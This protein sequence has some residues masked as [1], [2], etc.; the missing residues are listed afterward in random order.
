MIPLTADPT[1]PIWQQAN[2]CYL[3]ATCPPHAPPA[4][5]PQPGPRPHHPLR[6]TS[7]LPGSTP[8][9][10]HAISFYAPSSPCL[11][12]CPISHLPA[13]RPP[14]QAPRPIIPLPGPCL[15]LTLLL[16]QWYVLVL[17]V[18]TCN[19]AR[20]CRPAA[21]VPAVVSGMAA[22]EL[23][24]REAGGTACGL[25]SRT[26]SCTVWSMAPDTNMLSPVHG[27]KRTPKRLALWWVW[28][29]RGLRL[30]LSG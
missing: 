18:T 10:P 24:E 29:A 8:H 2:P 17:G 11:A 25:A 27:R 9:R 4:P 16:W 20:C 22:R 6:P 23:L 5:S 28:M 12:P 15:T 19:P 26:C 7:A 13:P 30:L 1:S 3:F 21:A 14:C